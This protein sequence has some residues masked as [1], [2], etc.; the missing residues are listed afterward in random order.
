VPAASLGRGRGAARWQDVMTLADPSV[1]DHQRR[2]VRKV[3]AETAFDSHRNR[4][5]G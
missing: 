2:L 1:V 5:P 3:V 4:E